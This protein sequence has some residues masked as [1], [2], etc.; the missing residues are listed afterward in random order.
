MYDVFISY[1]RKDSKVADEVVAALEKAGVSCFIDR[2][3]LSG[4]VDFPKVLANSIMDA[5]LLL[6]IA[7]KNSYESQFTQKEIA[8]AISRKG[9]HFVLPLR[10]DNT[11][12]PDSVD[13][14]LS[15]IN[16][17]QLSSTYTIE[18][19]LVN[20]VLGKLA[21]PHA[22]ETLVQKERRSSNRLLASVLILIAVV[23]ISLAGFI[24]YKSNQQKERE[25]HVLA[26]RV[27][28]AQLLDDANVWV[29]KAD[30]IAE[31]VG[32]KEQTF[33]DE[34]L[35][36]QRAQLSVTRAD[37]L[38]AVYRLDPN[39]VSLFSEFQTKDIQSSIEHSKRDLLEF[40]VKT[41]RVF[42]D[43]KD[44]PVFHDEAL[45]YVGYVLS[46]TPDDSLK[47]EFELMKESLLQP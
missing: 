40:W 3:G 1:S 17:R 21:D 33:E 30:S 38:I 41:A 32:H 22:G 9:S 10:I 47:S 28:C 8:F 37:S 31:N 12:F 39:Y 5:R 18:K 14:L 4:G 2:E 36:L 43:W 29:S 7:S 20:D 23:G 34:R 13:L 44:D 27:Q 26:D 42:Y 6:F 11:P 46:L 19:N 24:F 15:D 35:F 16:Y 25:A 45:K